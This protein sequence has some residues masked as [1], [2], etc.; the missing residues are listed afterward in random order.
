[1]DGNRAG[2]RISARPS[3]PR[4]AS[5]STASASSLDQP[6][7]GPAERGWRLLPGMVVEADIITGKKSMRYMLRPVYRS[8]NTAMSER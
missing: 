3:K 4:M 6:F 1:M 5:L 8:L 2:E 7:V